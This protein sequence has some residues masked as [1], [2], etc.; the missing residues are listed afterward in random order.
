MLVVPQ[1]A[2]GDSLYHTLA[3]NDIFNDKRVSFVVLNG[4][5]TDDFVRKGYG[6]CRLSIPDQDRGQALDL[7]CRE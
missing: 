6:P 2:P 5:W 7:R 4:G 3:F 1:L